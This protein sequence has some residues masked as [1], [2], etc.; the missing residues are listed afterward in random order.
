MDDRNELDVNLAMMGG[1]EAGPAHV[2]FVLEL[3]RHVRPSVLDIC[4]RD[5]ALSSRLGMETSR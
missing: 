3:R 2:T 4:K 5:V 1:L